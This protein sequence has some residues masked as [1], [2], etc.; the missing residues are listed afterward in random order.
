MQRNRIHCM[1]VPLEGSQHHLPVAVQ[2][3]D[4]VE[5]YHAS[6]WMRTRHTVGVVLRTPMLESIWP[7]R[8]TVH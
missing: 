8:G 5:L 7:V 2:L 3:S 4:D 1:P 6:S